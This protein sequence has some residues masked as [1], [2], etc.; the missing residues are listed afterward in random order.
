[1]Y[2]V[3]SSAS[4]T[5]SD[6]L[7]MSA[8]VSRHGSMTG[9]SGNTSATGATAAA[10]TAASTS[11]LSLHTSSEQHDSFDDFDEDVVDSAP[12]QPIGTCVALYP[13]D[14][15]SIGAETAGGRG[16][17]VPP[18]IWLGGDAIGNV[19]PNILSCCTC[20]DVLHMGHV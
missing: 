12:M 5:Q 16:G 8:N 15:M 9:G 17:H 7:T 19:P 4:S 14:G 11:P 20:T 13:F 10:A 3:V 1:M 6:R 2:V 18:I